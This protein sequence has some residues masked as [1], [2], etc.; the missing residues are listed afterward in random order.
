ML[1]AGRFSDPPR[2]PDLERLNL[3]TDDLSSL[4]GCRPG[5]CGLKLSVEMINRL[6][7][8]AATHPP[9]SRLQTEFRAILLEYLTSYIRKGT[10]GMI[11]YGDKDTPVRTSTEM[12]AILGEFDW[13]K[14]YTPQLL[15]C[16]RDPLHAWA[17]GMD[18]FLYWSQESFGLK[19]VVSLTQVL[20]LKTVIGGEQW[21]FIA[22][23]QLYA[24]HYF[25]TSLGLTVLAAESSDSANPWT[26]MSYFNRSQTDGLRGW[27]ESIKRSIVERRVRDGMA[28]SL[29]DL[30]ERLGKAYVNRVAR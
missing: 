11:V 6:R 23:K 30:R 17:P 16:L 12:A 4:A 3:V 27:F 1:G 25:Q 26:S 24:D 28:R 20:I 14:S 13:L 21:A 18:G 10:P 7:R 5:K 9:V 15:A 29:S 19:P 8:E 2:L 22:S